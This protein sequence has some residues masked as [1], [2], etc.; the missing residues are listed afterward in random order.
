VIQLLANHN[1]QD[2]H[3][4]KQCNYCSHS[5]SDLHWET[6]HLGNKMYKKIECPSCTKEIIL[7]LNNKTGSGHEIFLNNK[8]LK[9]YPEIIIKKNNGKISTLENKLKIISCKPFSK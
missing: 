5:L 6:L 1:F 2:E 3:T 4:K 7:G 9:N 8:I